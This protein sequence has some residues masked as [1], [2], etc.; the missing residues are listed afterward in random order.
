MDR[1]DLKVKQLI[2]NNVVKAPDSEFLQTRA[3]QQQEYLEHIYERYSHLKIVELPM[4]PQ[5]VK[6]LERLREVGRILFE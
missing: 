1:F 6:G 3:R 5:E 2:I 4:F